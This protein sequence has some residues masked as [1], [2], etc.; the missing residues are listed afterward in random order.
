MI[1][2]ELANLRLHQ[3]SFWAEKLPIS[4]QV[5]FATT[6]GDLET[7]EGSVKFMVGDAILTGI[8]G[9]SWPIS[10]EKFLQSYEAIPPTISGCAGEYVKRRMR[11]LCI[12]VD[13][14]LEVPLTDARGTVRAGPGD[15]LVQYGPGD[16]AVVGESIFHKTYKVLT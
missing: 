5:K 7:R 13:R 12:K 9:E 15:Y 14:D 1:N 4:V 6:S 3:A 16:L 10:R 8:E 11:V 2:F